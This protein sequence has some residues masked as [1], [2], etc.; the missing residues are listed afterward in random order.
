MQKSSSF[1]RT[2]EMAPGHAYSLQAI[3]YLQE[4]KDA[5]EGSE[6]N[7]LSASD[8]KNAR[9]TCSETFHEYLSSSHVLRNFV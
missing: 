6:S 2:T 8:P 9:Q 4:G 5:A 1:N 3:H 7:M